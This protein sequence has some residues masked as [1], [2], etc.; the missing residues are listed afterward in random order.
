MKKSIINKHVMVLITWLTNIKI[1]TSTSHPPILFRL[2]I[3]ISN[4]T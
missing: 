1:N 3:N 2:D 4:Q